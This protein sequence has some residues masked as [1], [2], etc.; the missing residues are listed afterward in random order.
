MN[1]TSEQLIQTEADQHH[2]NWQQASEGV[3]IAF[4]SDNITR[5]GSAGL[6][7][8]GGFKPDENTLFEIG[9]ITKVF[10]S[11]LLAETVREH[12]AVLDDS[13]STHLA[14]LKF[15]KD[16]PF[17]SITLSELATHTSG[18]PRL[19]GALSIGADRDNPYAHYDEQ[20]LIQS[21]ISFRK[22]QLHEPGEYGYSNY[23]AGILGYVLTQIYGQ[24]YRNLLKQKILD[25]LKMNSTDAPTR[26]SDL[27]EDLRARIATPHSAGRAVSHW[28]L[29][30]L[31]G[32]GGMISSAEDLIRFGTA[33]WNN[34][35]LYGL[36]ASLS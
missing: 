25:P 8:N 17:H 16:S 5:Y 36:A 11:L 3:V 30:A 23:G 4:H 22:N 6:T 27:S 1:Q 9:S 28:E 13:V 32:A 2:S 31:I 19:P 12:K 21:L 29:S 20:R 18:L 26:F 35:S 33:H 34:E 7:R 14:A 15:K 24:T 10:T